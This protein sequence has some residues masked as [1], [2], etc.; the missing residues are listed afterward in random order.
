MNKLLYWTNEWLGWIVE[1]MNYCIALY[2]IVLLY[3]IVEIDELFN[4]WI[5]DRMNAFLYWIIEWMNCYIELLYWIV[6]W[7]NYCIIELINWR[8]D[9]NNLKKINHS[10]GGKRTCIYIYISI[11]KMV[12]WV[13]KTKIERLSWTWNSD[14]W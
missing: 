12:C 2:W 6:K 7:M 9:E 4:E 10:S 5:V 3:L 1:W 14:P 13:Q 8:K 11:M